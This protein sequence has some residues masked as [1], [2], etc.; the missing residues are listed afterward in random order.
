[1]IEFGWKLHHFRLITEFDVIEGS[2]GG[3]ELIFEFYR[4]VTEDKFHA[5]GL[6]EQLD[7]S[8]WWSWVFDKW[9][10]R[11]K[12]VRMT[13]WLDELL[14]SSQ[15]GRYV[16]VGSVDK[17]TEWEWPFRSLSRKSFLNALFPL[18]YVEPHTSHALVGTKWNSVIGHCSWTHYTVELSKIV[19]LYN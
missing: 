6:P 7:G 15:K 1:M 16:E 5:V 9:Q 18:W 12:S 14:G 13:F 3:G 2:A 11:M 4:F 8:E 19:D 17:S 10:M